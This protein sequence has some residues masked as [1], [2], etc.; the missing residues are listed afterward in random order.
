M[1]F[2]EVAGGSLNEVENALHFMKRNSVCPTETLRAA[3]ELRWKT[4][5]LLFG[6]ARSLRSK[7]KNNENWQR[8]LIK[9]Q[10]AEYATGPSNDMFPVPSSMFLD[11]EA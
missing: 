9:E 3:E 10:E 2:L 5:N 8:G 1:R 11:A 7:Q 6:L 4:G